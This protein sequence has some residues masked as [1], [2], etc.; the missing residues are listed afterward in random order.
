MTA[1]PM[2]LD[3]HKGQTR[4][5]LNLTASLLRSPRKH[6]PK[7][8]RDNWW[9]FDLRVTTAQQA[10]R[11]RRKVLHGNIHGAEQ[12]A[13]LPGQLVC[14]AEHLVKQPTI[15][16]KLSIPPIGSHMEGRN[17][18]AKGVMSAS[19]G[20]AGKMRSQLQLLTNRVRELKLELDE[21]RIIP[22]AEG[23]VERSYRVRDVLDQVYRILKGEDEQPE[24]VVHIGT[25]DIARKRNEDLKSE[26]KELGWKLKGRTS[27][28]VI[29]GLVPVLWASEARNSDRVQLN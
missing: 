8:F 13:R 18:S 11:L 20:A 25:N 9:W 22:E 15:I 24:V 28:V 1:L 17:V 2:G 3:S 10:E 4:L 16:P 7:K 19:Q 29:S 6:V 14:D 5:I 27:R 21:L 26:Y 23:M 12:L